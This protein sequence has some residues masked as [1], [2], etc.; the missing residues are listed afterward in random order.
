M[1]S[2]SMI[3]HGQQRQDESNHSNLQTICFTKS[4][5]NGYLGHLSENPECASFALSEYERHLLNLKREP[6]AQPCDGE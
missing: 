1:I 6:W 5:K 2:C 3:P 4:Q